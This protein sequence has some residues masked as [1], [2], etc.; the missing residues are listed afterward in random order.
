[1]LQSP[2][3]LLMS[4]RGRGNWF[5][6]IS[7]PPRHHGFEH[8]SSISKAIEFMFRLREATNKGAESMGEGGKRVQTSTVKSEAV[9]NIS[10]LWKKK[11]NNT[12]MWKEKK[13]SQKKKKKYIYIH[14]YCT[15]LTVPPNLICH[16]NY[17]IEVLVRYAKM[18]V[19]VWAHVHGSWQ[20]TR[21]TRWFPPLARGKIFFISIESPS[22]WAELQERW[23]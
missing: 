12:E 6:L 23:G 8:L 16:A 2:P 5:C 4:R 1:M 21:T 19:C 10:R 9:K 15:Y 3:N 22:E 11:N 20:L 14:I 17:Q 7:K 18:R 13:R